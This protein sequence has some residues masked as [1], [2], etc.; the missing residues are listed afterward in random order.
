MANNMMQANTV[1]RIRLRT[2]FVGGIITLLFLI[3]I[4][5]IFWVQVVNADFWL[6]EAK[7]IWAA[8]DTIP[9]ERGTISD[10]KGNML[11]M[12]VPAYTVV[13]N[14]K[15]LDELGLAEEAAKGLS[16]IIGKPEQEV[17]A[18][19]T[20][21]NSKGVL[22]QYREL[23]P[24]GWNI[25]KAK[26]DEVIAFRTSLKESYEKQADKKIRDTGISLIEGSKRFYPSGSLAAHVL[27]YVNKEGNPVTGMEANYN[28]LLQGTDGKI[29]YEKDGNRVQ[30]DNGNAEFVPAVN[31]KDMELTIDTEIQNFLEAAIKEAYDKYQPDS[32]TAI[33][34]DPNT[35]E[36]LGM[37][38]LPTYN[39][40]QYSKYNVASQFN[41]AISSLYEPGSTF[42]ILTLASA[43]QEGIFNPNATY[44]SG[45]IQVPGKRI[46][47]IKREGWG[48]IT[49]LEG[50]K[51]SSNVS[52]VKLGYEQLGK[53]KLV[54]YFQ[55]FGFGKQTGIEIKNEAKGRLDIVYPLE[56]AAATFGQGVSV[57]PIQQVAAVAAVANGGK[58]MKPHIVKSVT[59]PATGKVT[60][61]KP[62]MVRQVISAETSRKVGGY[63][64]QVVSDQE[65]GSGKNA[66]IPGY[67]VA[68]KTGT[69]QKAEGNGYSTEDY[70]VS[71]IGYAPVDN[72]KIVVYVIIDSPNDSLVSGG[73]AA[74][75][76]F[77]KIVSNSLRYMG[78][79][80]DATA[81]EAD[82]KQDP[83]TVPNL[84][85]FGAK[86]AQTEL[87]SRGMESKV[88]GKGSKVLLQIPAAGAVLAQKQRVYLITEEESKITL[89]SL[90]GLSLRDALQICSSTGKRCVTEGE[91]YVVKQTDAKLNGEPV[92][93]LTLQSPGEENASDDTVKSDGKDGEKEESKGNK[94]NQTND[95]DK[96]EDADPPG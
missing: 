12:N 96:K 49:Y 85:G 71:F 35:M 93:K 3:L 27:G 51:R 56:V 43:V 40:N 33:A 39:P 80:P 82:G 28:E 78:V 7:K 30:V 2:V 73:R 76:V 41:H 70:V 20:A 11:A 64:E 13:V 48:T 18:Q 1:K 24:E 31:G 45:S 67:R 34:A 10:R 9:A 75:P 88:V 38:N 29:V 50:L 54:K 81:E 66:Y 5:R 15:L 36:I 59:D 63:L 92:V 17:L 77:K 23:R 52:F 61:T 58:L 95:K 94:Q 68:G 19:T 16:K 87:K 62:E 26:A 74:A 6:G 72:P 83:V 69:A 44:Q 86:Q 79:K 42:K 90:T 32:I 89:P 46:R 14:P 25:D 8:Q 55:D 91:G 21:K 4:S 22:L 47:D 37:G 57:T 65:I 84:K 53:E 60:E